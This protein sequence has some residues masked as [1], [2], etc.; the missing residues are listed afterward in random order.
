MRRLL[1]LPAG[2]LLLAGTLACEPGETCRRTDCKLL[3]VGTERASDGTNA[4]LGTRWSFEAGGGTQVTQVAFSSVDG[5]S[6]G[7]GAAARW[8]TDLNIGARV[9]CSYNPLLVHN[10]TRVVPCDS[11]LLSPVSSAGPL[12]CCGYHVVLGQTNYY[13]A[14][15]TSHVL[16][17]LVVVLTLVLGASWVCLT[18]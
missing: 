15:N 8:A 6:S 16:A 1:H 12:Q 13:P 11:G 17:S 9:P 7:G 10:C 18:S 4:R 3:S 2:L 14:P 5:A